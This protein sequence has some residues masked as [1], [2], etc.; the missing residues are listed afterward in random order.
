MRCPHAFLAEFRKPVSTAGFT[1]IE[2][3]IVL[4]IIGLIVGGVVVGRHLIRSAELQSVVTDVHRYTEAV[5]NF[6][7]MYN[8]LPGDMAN[9]TSY[10]GTNTGGDC[11]SSYTAVASATSTCNGDGNGQIDGL[12]GSPN[13]S[14]PYEADEGFLAWRHLSNAGFIEGSYSG[15]DAG[16][17]GA[18]YV[19]PAPGHLP[20]VPLSRVPGAGFLIITNL[21]MWGPGGSLWIY[22][23][24][25]VTHVIVFGGNYPGDDTLF[26]AVITPEEALGL[27][28]KT[29][30]GKPG[31][32][33]IKSPRAVNSPWGT[34]YCADNA[35]P[36]LANYNVAQTGI[37]CSLLFDIE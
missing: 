32:G 29:D 31:T 36:N 23:W 37:A 30:D 24:T 14:S 4:V 11:S 15:Q 13:T 5:H 7:Q 22:P 19:Q 18:V 17:A 12:G 26:G 6:Q 8:A 3:A 2:L 1:L 28:L 20:Q 10:W 21:D 25:H 35:D 9:A 27:D 33:A 16:A 34:A